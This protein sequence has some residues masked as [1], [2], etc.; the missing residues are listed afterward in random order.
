MTRRTFVL[1]AAIVAGSMLAGFG[2][3]ALAADAD[4]YGPI[5]DVKLLKPEDKEDV[6]PTP[7]PDGA[8]VLFDGKGLDKWVKA[9]LKVEEGK[10][11]GQP[12][13]WK[14]VDG[15]AVQA[16]GGNIMTKEMFP[17]PFH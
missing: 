15:G 7:P 5:T 17:G 11:E 1:T 16:G 2:R 9:D 13:T 14:L 10:A 4:P 8:T 6:K 12:A 3:P